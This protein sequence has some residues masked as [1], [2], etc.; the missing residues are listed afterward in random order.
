MVRELFRKHPA[1]LAGLDLVVALRERLD[2]ARVSDFEGEVR[3]L[4][5]QALEKARR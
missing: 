1:K 2:P 5:D 4:L 3:A